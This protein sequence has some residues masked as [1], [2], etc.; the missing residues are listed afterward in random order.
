MTLEDFY[1]EYLQEMKEGGRRSPSKSW[2]PD[3][4]VESLP[5]VFVVETDD[6]VRYMTMTEDGRLVNVEDW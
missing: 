6:G 3:E 5:H 4:R 2:S 1:E